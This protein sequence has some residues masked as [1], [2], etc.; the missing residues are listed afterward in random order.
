M[1]WKTF[2]TECLEM[3]TLKLED[4]VR[5]V[6][7]NRMLEARQWVADAQRAGLR[8]DRLPRPTLV[9]QAELAVAAGLAELLASRHGQSPPSWAASISGLESPMFL[10]RQLATLPRSAARARREGPE[11][12]KRRN[13][14][15][16][17]NFLNVV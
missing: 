6:L 13:L 3:A 10:G 1:L 11:P 14:L 9:D 16:L 4:L 8:F 12:L 17:P 2:G 7:D 15:A 5:F